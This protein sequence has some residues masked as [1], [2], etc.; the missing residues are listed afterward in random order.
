MDCSGDSGIMEGGNDAPEFSGNN[1]VILPFQAIGDG[2]NQAYCDGLTETVATR[3]ESLAQSNDVQVVSLSE[4]RKNKVRTVDDARVQVGRAIVV[5]GSLQHRGSAVR[6]DYHII[7]AVNRKTIHAEDMVLNAEDVFAV[8]DR[9]ADSVARAVGL[10]A[11]ADR[12]PRENHPGLVAG[13]YDYYLQGRG[14]LQNFDKPENLDNAA[15]VFKRALSVDPDFGLAY[16]GLGETYW[17]RFQ[18][19][20]AEVQIQRSS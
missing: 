8:Q 16:A 4:V 9:L 14:Y 3:L 5:E 20:V 11:P 18:S 1:V 10:A 2:V 12:V 17:H 13:A 19:T 15:S 7:D 6:I